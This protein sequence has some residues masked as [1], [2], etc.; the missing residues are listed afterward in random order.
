MNNHFYKDTSAVLDYQF[1]WSSWLDTEEIII[2]SDVTVDEGLTLSDKVDGDTTVIV[3]LSGG[4][5]AHTYFVNCKITTSD[6][7]IDEKFMIISCVDYL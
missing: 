3:W 4:T 7:R 6:S 5:D 1:D 2:S